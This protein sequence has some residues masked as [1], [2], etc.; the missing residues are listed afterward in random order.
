[1]LPAGEVVPSGQSV[2]AELPAVS[3]K[4]F[5]GH[6]AQVALF[7]AS[8]KEPGGQGVQTCPLTKDPA[9]QLTSG[10]QLVLP[11]GDDVPAGHSVHSALPTVFEKV[12][13]GHGEQIAPP[14]LEKEPAWHGEQVSLPGSDAE[15]A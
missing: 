6:G 15:P 1:M 9:G 13:G 12:L 4:V 14:A 10:V 2:H 8:E 7:A 11:A 3:A 5:G